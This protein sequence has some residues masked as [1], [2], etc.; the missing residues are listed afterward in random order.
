MSIV[1]TAEASGSVKHL[2]LGTSR[3]APLRRLPVLDAAGAVYL[4]GG[5][6]RLSQALGD[7]LPLLCQDSQQVA[8]S[9]LTRL[10]SC[11]VLHRGSW[12][13]AGQGSVA[14]Q[15]LQCWRVMRPGQQGKWLTGAPAPALC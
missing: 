8:H 14:R 12:V 10:S 4:H 13:E 9:L 15:A 7:W 11:H 6:A 3:L 5:R 2:D 1:C